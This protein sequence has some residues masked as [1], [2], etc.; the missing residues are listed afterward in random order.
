MNTYAGFRIP[1]K[2]ETANA[3]IFPMVCY[4]TAA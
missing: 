3:G 4:N 1:E 2:G